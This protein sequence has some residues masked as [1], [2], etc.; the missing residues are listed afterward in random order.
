MSW[1]TPE[2]RET[3]QRNDRLAYMAGAMRVGRMREL[4]LLN[5]RAITST[6]TNE[7]L[8]ATKLRRAE[9][10]HLEK[11][12]QGLSIGEI[13]MGWMAIDRN[14]DPNHYYKLTTDTRD[15]ML[16]KFNAANTPNL[17]TVA[18][19]L[20]HLA[21]PPLE[22]KRPRAFDATDVTVLGLVGRGVTYAH[23]ASVF[24]KPGSYVRNMCRSLKSALPRGEMTPRGASAPWL[25]HTVLRLGVIPNN[26]DVLEHL[27]AAQLTEGITALMDPE[28]TFRM[29][30]E[31]SAITIAAVPFYE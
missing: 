9:E 3:S 17:V 25:M 31:N 13:A 11:T 4:L 2:Y 1:I 15:D 7:G 5:G 8:L 10:Y 27:D 6:A 28:R 29:P 22:L 26:P 23:I 16:F 30:P 19:T 24:D 14:G 20:G 18:S 21:C 12:A